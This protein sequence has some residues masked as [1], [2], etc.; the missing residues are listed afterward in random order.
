MQPLGALSYY[1]IS[2]ILILLVDHIT[3]AIDEQLLAH[4]AGEALHQEVG[5]GPEVEAEGQESPLPEDEPDV[6]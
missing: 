3:V 5:N 4:V 2:H 1:S 6:G